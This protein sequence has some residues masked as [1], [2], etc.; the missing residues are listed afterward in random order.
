[1]KWAAIGVLAVIGLALTWTLLPA[2]EWLQVAIERIDR[3]GVWGIAVYFLLYYCLASVTFPTTPLN[4]GAGLIFHFAVGFFVAWL[5]GGLASM[6]A[7]LF[8]R[9]VAKTWARK[10]LADF[11]QC[12]RVVEA[13]ERQGFKLVLLTRLNPFIPASIKNF[14]FAVTAVPFWKYATGTFL[15]QFPLV[16]AHV[17]LGWAGN[18]TILAGDDESA[19]STTLICIGIIVS[20]VMLALVNWFGRRTLWGRSG[21]SH[22]LTQE[23]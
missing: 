10:Q 6:T 8:C 17:Y 14:G 11:P 21:S 7:F 23:S 5:A 18:S 19:M 12:A 15:G 22:T 3:L 9:Y 13:V 2:R 4:V 16:L 1:M 20:I